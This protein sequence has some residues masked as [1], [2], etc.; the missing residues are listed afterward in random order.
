MGWFDWLRTTYVYQTKTC[1]LIIFVLK[2]YIYPVRMDI[3]KDKSEVVKLGKTYRW[4]SSINIIAFLTVFAAGIWIPFYYPELSSLQRGELRLAT[5]EVHRVIK[6]KPRTSYHIKLKDS[7]G[8]IQSFRYLN[9]VIDESVMKEFK[10]KQATVGY[11]VGLFGEK[12]LVTI[13]AEGS[14]HGSVKESMVIKEKQLTGIVKWLMV[15]FPIALVLP[16]IRYKK[17]GLI[18]FIR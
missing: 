4:I 11:I 3:K 17:Y 9:S 2:V 12:K 1:K 18:K 8:V 10:G 5:G 13:R 14:E 16:W 6:V 15:A 7:D